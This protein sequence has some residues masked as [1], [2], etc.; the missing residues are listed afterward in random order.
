MKTF[1][2]LA[3][4]AFALSATAAVAHGNK[5]DKSAQAPSGLSSQNLQQDE[6]LVRQAQQTLNDKGFDAG[7]TSGTV[8]AKTQSAVK[9]FQQAQGIA[10]SGQLD[11]PT[12]AALGIQVAADTSLD[13]ASR[14]ST[15]QYK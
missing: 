14:S 8:D 7:S 2:K 12:L 3:I 9:K 11:Q 6:S 13:D 10:P 15:N 5:Q 1:S 4:A